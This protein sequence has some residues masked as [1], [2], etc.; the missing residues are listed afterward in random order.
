GPAAYE[1][2]RIVWSGA[3]AGAILYLFAHPIRLW[4]AAALGLPALGFAVFYGYKAD[5]ATTITYPIMYGT[6]AVVHARQY[7]RSQGFASAF[8]AVCAAVQAAMC[9]A[10]YTTIARGNPELMILGYA[11]YATVSILAVLLGWVHLPREIRGR[12]PV[13]MSPANAR[14]F[15]A[16]FMGL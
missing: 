16:A 1:Q 6:V 12:S 5:L 11:N 4:A 15:A 14:I 9:A 13:R 3:Y 10:Y 2:L 8:L 7:L